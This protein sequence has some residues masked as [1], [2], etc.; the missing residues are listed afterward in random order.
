MEIY[1]TSLSNLNGTLKL[2]NKAIY[3][4]FKYFTLELV[5]SSNHL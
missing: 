3:F 4:S 5:E 2:R 1:Y